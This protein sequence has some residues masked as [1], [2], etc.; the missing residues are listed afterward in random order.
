MERDLGLFFGYD[1][2]RLHE[3]LFERKKRLGLFSERGPYQD[4]IRKI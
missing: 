2:R 3:D 4:E 1:G